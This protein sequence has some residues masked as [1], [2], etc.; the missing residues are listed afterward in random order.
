MAEKIKQIKRLLIFSQVSLFGLLIFCSLLKPQVVKGNGGVSNFGKYR[1]TVI[2][3]ILS[4][5]LEMIFIWLA[6][7][8][9]AIL[10]AKYRYFSWLLKFLASLVLLVLISTFP[11]YISNIYSIVHDDLGIALYGFEFIASIWFVI[12]TK[13]HSAVYLLII[14]S[15]GS[16][17]GLLSIL[18]ITHLLYIGQFIG[19]LGFGLLLILAYPLILDRY[20][21]AFR[22][23]D[24]PKLSI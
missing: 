5:L 22:S 2:F 24:H 4:F 20:Y 6:A 14:E 16:M 15:A 19:A 17:I 7:Y 10:G 23:V 9:I 13:L 18:K 8:R 3:Y 1:L 12:K 11:R 21:Q